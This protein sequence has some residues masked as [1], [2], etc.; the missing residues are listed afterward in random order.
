MIYSCFGHIVDRK[1]SKFTAQS[2]FH[3]NISNLRELFLTHAI[4]KAAL[5][6]YIPWYTK[7][8]K[9][10]TILHVYTIVPYE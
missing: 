3:K 10:Y 4:L 8:I 5:V 9:T 1:L 2:D 6:S 7:N